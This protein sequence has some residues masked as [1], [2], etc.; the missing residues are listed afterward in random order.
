MEFQPATDMLDSL[1][2]LIKQL[3]SSDKLRSKI[4][5]LETGALTKNIFIKWLSAYYDIKFTSYLVDEL[6]EN[7][8]TE[9]YFQKWFIYPIDEQAEMRDFLRKFCDH[10][11]S[12]FA[13]TLK[14]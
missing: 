5:E 11:A 13:D 6:L 4:V 8:I 12:A 7:K 2:P 10:L 14:T 3:E 9:E 1:T